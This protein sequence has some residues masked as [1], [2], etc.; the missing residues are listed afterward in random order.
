MQE[1][2]LV[3]LFQQ[4][5]V[6]SKVQLLRPTTVLEVSIVQVDQLE[7]LIPHVLLTN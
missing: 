4:V 7:N 5:R 6:P 3:P 2:Q 1:L